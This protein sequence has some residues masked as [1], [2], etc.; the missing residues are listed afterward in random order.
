[1]ELEELKEHY[2]VLPMWSRLLVAVVIGLA[3]GAYV[4][5]DQGQ[6]LQDNLAAVQMQEDGARTKF[7]KARRQKANLPKLEEQL[8]FTQEQLAKAKRKLPDSYRIEDVL[9]KAATIA[10]ETGVGLLR[11]DAGDEIPHNETYHYVEL[12]I[13][14]EVQGRFAQLASYFDRIVHLDGSIFLRHIELVRAKNQTVSQSNRRKSAYQLAKEAR[15]NL[16]LKAT[17]ELVVYRGMSDAEVA[18][19]TAASGGGAGAKGKAKQG[20]AAPKGNKVSLE[21]SAARLPPVAA[22]KRQD[23]DEAKRF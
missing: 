16:R 5:Y 8:S 17:F 13:V 10:K 2:K 12:P 3:P 4:Y 14:T 23:L 15:Q 19:A 1:M 18:A 9:E 22:G 7:E 21:G 6:T 11:F 20:S